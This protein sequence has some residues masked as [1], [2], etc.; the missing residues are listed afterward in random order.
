MTLWGDDELEEFEDLSPN[1]L[2]DAA[3][4][5]ALVVILG[6][7]VAAYDGLISTLAAVGLLGLAGACCLAVEWARARP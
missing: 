1:R 2:A 5:L 3:L 7:A 6:A 4:W